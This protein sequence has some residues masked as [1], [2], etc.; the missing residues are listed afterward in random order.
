MSY[1]VGIDVGTTFTAAAIHRNGAARIFPLSERKI[2]APTMV[3][4]D[5]SGRLL[6][7]W[8]AARQLRHHPEQVVHS[9]KRRVGDPT[10]IPL[11]ERAYEP[12]WYMAQVISAVVTEITRVEGDAP[13]RITLTHPATWKA[14]KIT[15][16]LEAASA[17][18]LAADA[19]VLLSEPE[20]AAMTRATTTDGTDD[21]MIAVYDLGGG[22][23][24]TA[25][26]WRARDG[27][28]VVGAPE[29]IERLGGL[30]FDAA[31]YRYA[32]DQLSRSLP[33]I[34][35]DDHN[36]AQALSHLHLDCVVAKEALSFEQHAP[37]SLEIGGRSASI[38]VQRQS[39]EAL[40]RPTLM[41]T[42]RALR[43][44]LAS[45]R[46]DADDLSEILLTG[47][48]SQIPL[49]T[50]LLSMELGRPV[51]VHPAPKEL[52]ALG[53]AYAAARE[54]GVEVYNPSHANGVGGQEAQPTVAW[55]YANGGP[56]ANGNG[57][58]PEVAALGRVEEPSTNGAATAGEVV[59]TDA[60]AASNGHG[61]PP[62]L[63]SDGFRYRPASLERTRR[64]AGGCERSAVIG[65]SG[66]IRWR[67]I[68]RFPDA[69][70]PPSRTTNLRW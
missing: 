39:F 32:I 22:S 68:C 30:D 28:Q 46:I 43:R 42:I 5:E 23:F 26:L 13:N 50:E 35:P 3:A 49:V 1:R 7:G 18:G 27:Y 56:A 37:L 67:T 61:R 65:P 34:D 14:H 19:I 38:T 59:R 40:I 6:V 52:V 63:L 4:K 53:A 21:S 51:S 66:T 62:S 24:D 15:R 31:L 33:A 16:L 55:V 20:A 8:S 9:F 36:T 41:E 12:S 70:R 17:A 47:G 11:G 54:D 25:T 45:A 58:V 29:G 60:P 57:P 69:D 10:P 64:G 2:V 44:C 48:S